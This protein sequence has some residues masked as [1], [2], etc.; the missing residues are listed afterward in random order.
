VSLGD[1]QTVLEIGAAAVAVIGGIVAGIAWIWK[2]V[3]RWGSRL[4]QFADDWFGTEARPGVPARPG[5]MERLT[6]IE[7]E[8][9]HN[10]GHSIKDAVLRLEQHAGT[11]P[12]QLPARGRHARYDTQEFERISA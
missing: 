1:T 11:L 8:L 9:S 5:V 7:G 10:H 3:R 12:T 4:G 6:V 2:R